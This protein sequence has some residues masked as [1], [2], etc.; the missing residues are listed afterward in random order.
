MKTIKAFL[1]GIFTLVL[2]VA[3]LLYAIDVFSTSTTVYYQYNQSE[4]TTFTTMFVV[5]SIIL[6]ALG[7]QLMLFSLTSFKLFIKYHNTYLH[8]KR[9]REVQEQVIDE[10]YNQLY[11]DLADAPTI[12]LKEAIIKTFY[13]DEPKERKP[14]DFAD[15]MEQMKRR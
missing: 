9:D 12:E 13:E 14:M 8:N 2:S 6:F 4:P 11:K 5:I 10:S 1:I 7:L 15:F 3:S